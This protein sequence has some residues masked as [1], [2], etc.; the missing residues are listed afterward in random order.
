MRTAVMADDGDLMEPFKLQ[1][2]AVLTVEGFSALTMDEMTS[3]TQCHCQE[4][5]FV[6]ALLW[7][8]H[9]L[10]LLNV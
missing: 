4:R 2:A 3:C 1:C 9:S 5:F 7:V 6:T 8:I 10:F